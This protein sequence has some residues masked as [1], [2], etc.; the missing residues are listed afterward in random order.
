MTLKT[1]FKGLMYFLLTF[2]VTTVSAQNMF[3]LSGWT[4]GSGSVTDFGKY[5][6]TTSNIRELG[7]NHVGD[8]VVLWKAVPDA[9]SNAEGGIY[10]AYKNI[11]N[12]KTYRLSVWVKKTNSNDGRT[13]FGCHSY[14][15]GT[16]HTLSVS[17]GAVNTNPYFWSGDLPKLNHWYLLVGYV[18]ANNYTGAKLGKIYDGETGEVVLDVATD[19]K[20]SST[21]TN[22]R[23]RAF[24][25]NDPNL[26]DRQFLYE[27]HMELVDG[28][29]SSITQLLKINSNSKLL[30][31]YDNAG[32]QKQRFYCD[33]PGCTVPTP[34]AGKVSEEEII[35]L[36]DLN[37]AEDIENLKTKES[38]LEKEISLHP[39]PTKGIV[40]LVVNSKVNF[41]GVINV[42][43][44]AGMLISKIPSNSKNQVEINLSRFPV[45]MYFVHMHLS[46]GESV[47]RKVIKK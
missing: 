21:A 45:G 41:S 19:F 28:T 16:H 31:A 8:N 32:N 34:P 23:L 24:L 1:R 36:N 33:V 10:S 9:A 3:N 30:F 46:S 47:T 22:L 43:N 26:E 5:G 4:V 12:T 27:P 20:F 15:S 17:S 37:D 35:T 14:V 13:Y 44:N 6:A 11:D 38:V 7:Y 29:E 40:S 42:Y 18:H 2:L 25:Y 39:N